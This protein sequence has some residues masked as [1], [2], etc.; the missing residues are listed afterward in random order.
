ML[1][2][3]MVAGEVPKGWFLVSVLACGLV[4]E[5]VHFAMTLPKLIQISRQF[6][7]VQAE[8]T[9]LLDTAEPGLSPATAPS[10]SPHG[11][12]RVSGQGWHVQAIHVCL[13]CK[14]DQRQEIAKDVLVAATVRKIS[15][16][17]ASFSGPEALL[18]MDRM[19]VKGKKMMRRRKR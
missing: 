18:E 3:V 16:A 9:E 19:E 17:C 14:F 12:S 7:S 10:F 1:W 6:Y 5:V 13:K 11:L 2:V 15:L 4:D 8:R